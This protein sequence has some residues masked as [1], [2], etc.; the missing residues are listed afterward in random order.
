MG[1]ASTAHAHRRSPSS[2]SNTITWLDPG[3]STAPRGGASSG[4]PRREADGRLPAI[5]GRCSLV[6]LVAA[7]SERDQQ[8]RRDSGWAGE[9]L[10]GGALPARASLAAVQPAG[11]CRLCARPPPG[12]QAPAPHPRRPVICRSVPPPEHTWPGSILQ[13]CACFRCQTQ[14]IGVFILSSFLPLFQ[15][16]SISIL[17]PVQTPLTAHLESCP[18]EGSFCPACS[19]KA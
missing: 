12:V 18:C 8:V 6:R 9:G 1:L 17:G 7:S 2:G 3:Q 14:E 11:L 4:V 13:A 19:A 5:I 10:S 16:S 15:W